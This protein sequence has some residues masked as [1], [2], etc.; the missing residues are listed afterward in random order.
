MSL[1]DLMAQVKTTIA[2]TE[3]SF[4]LGEQ[5]ILAVLFLLLLSPAGS[6]PSAILQLR[7]GDIRVVLQRDPLGGPHQLMIK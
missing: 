6:R 1:A 2:T 7:F 5:R 4:N 3:K